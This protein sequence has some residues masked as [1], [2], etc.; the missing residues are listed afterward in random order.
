MTGEEAHVSTTGW[1]AHASTTGEAAH[2]ST[3]GGFA[4]ASTTGDYAHATT[5]GDDAHAATT[6]W[7]AH[8]ATT[9]ESAIAA[10]LGLRGRVKATHGPLVAS[11]R[12]A[13]DRLRVAV[14]YPGEDGI[15]PDVWYAV[16]ERGAFVRD[17]DLTIGDGA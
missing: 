10:A 5:T 14:A 17:L 3:T 7:Y 11:Y 12:D 16:D 4:H 9:G 13:D 2:A 6:G 1:Y 8:A 15:E